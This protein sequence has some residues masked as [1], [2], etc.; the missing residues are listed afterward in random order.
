M[1]E[2]TDILPR[3]IVEVE[4][5]SELTATI[6]IKRQRKPL[7]GEIVNFFK[8]GGSRTIS[9]LVIGFLT[10]FFVVSVLLLKA[11]RI[12]EHFVVMLQ[13][14]RRE[15]VYNDA[16]TFIAVAFL[17]IFLVVKMI[18]SK[19][20]QEF[21][22][23]GVLQES[24]NTGEKNQ[25]S[26]IYTFIWIA[27]IAQL[28]PRACVFA[29]QNS[30][31]ESVM[32][33]MDR[34]AG[35]IVTL[36]QLLSNFCTEISLFQLDNRFLFTTSEKWLKVTLVAEA[37]N[38]LVVY[39]LI[40]DIEIGN[41]MEKGIWIANSII[42][43]VHSIA[44]CY[45]ALMWVRRFSHCNSSE[46]VQVVYSPIKLHMIRA[47]ILCLCVPGLF[48]MTFRI[49]LSAYILHAK[50][51]AAMVRASSTMFMGY[52]IVMVILYGL[53]GIFMLHVSLL[54]TGEIN[55]IQVPTSEPSPIFGVLAS[56][57]IEEEAEERACT[58]K[59]S[60]DEIVSDID[61]CSLDMSVVAVCGHLQCQARLD[62]TFCLFSSNPKL[63][64]FNP[65][66]ADVQLRSGNSKT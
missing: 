59:S 10:S 34:H 48:T 6:G 12:N 43:F 30:I 15:T 38:M 28:L 45:P 46:C 8:F 26:L 22:M 25:N 4:E 3:T 53:L 42:T 47:L 41:R 54:T 40:S 33:T 27:V 7:L 1:D 55:A 64:G 66:V 2:E 58:E 63:S 65:A 11:C 52:N 31:D 32:E 60:E 5:D 35:K 49:A 14:L 51:E 24:V 29:V 44:Y 9:G 50:E 23:M 39:I 57:T 16:V 17:L 18:F 62:T 21:R 61:D 19:S 13:Y 36:L 56:K 37:I 20:N